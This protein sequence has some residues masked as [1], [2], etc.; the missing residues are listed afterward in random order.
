VVGVAARP[1]GP[2]HDPT[3]EQVEHPGEI[4]AA[5]VGVELGDVGL[6]PLVGCR[7]A[8]V[9]LDQIRGGCADLVP[10]PAPAL[11]VRQ[12]G[13]VGLAHQ[14]TDALVVHAEA[15]PAE[16]SRDP[17]PPVGAQER[18]WTSRAI[19]PPKTIQVT[20]LRPDA[21]RCTGSGTEAPSRQAPVRRS[22]TCLCGEHVAG[23][24]LLRLV[25]RCSAVA[26]A[27]AAEA[28]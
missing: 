12:P 22:K 10:A 6:P 13:E 8:E 20:Q 11:A 9:P 28:S 1:Y 27:V 4:E 14:A 17:G 15:P 5:L 7:G 19:H 3:A 18:S 25:S 24:P 16:L 26:R 21:N 2:A 23:R